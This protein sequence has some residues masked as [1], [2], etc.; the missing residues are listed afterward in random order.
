M[1][2]ES[3]QLVKPAYA[4]RLTARFVDY[5]PDQGRILWRE[6]VKDKII[7]DPD[8]IAFL[9]ARGAPVE[10]IETRST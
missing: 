8:T 7:T 10:P 9:E 2:E 3:T 5:A 1:T 4:L 6:F